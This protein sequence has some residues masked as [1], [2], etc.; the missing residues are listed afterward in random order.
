[1][2]ALKQAMASAAVDVEA[3]LQRVM[4]SEDEPERRLFDSMRYAALG[5]GKRL[6]PFLVLQG[7]VLFSV[8]RK[9]A[10]RAAAAIELVHC[11]SLVHDDLP[12]MD[13]DDLRRGKP[14]VHKAFDEATA[15]LAG[16]ALL[17]LAFE[18]LAHPDTH[19]NPEV[20]CR[21]V[22]ELARAAGAHGMV[23]GQMIDLSASGHEM[24][25][26]EI[27]R[28]QRLKTGALIGFACEAGAILGQA[29]ESQH[30][31]LRG[32]AHDLGL[33]FQI[34]D[35]LLD[36]EGT[37][38]EV[39]KAVQKD[40][41]RGKATFVSILG[42]DRARDQARMLVEQAAAHLAIFEEKADF[43]RKVAQYV[44]ERRS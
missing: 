4:A 9:S 40:S 26:G 41:D 6:R 12:A 19:S 18:V 5:G 32:Y 44:V 25:I 30:E 2:D 23:A 37:Q 21:L 28:L 13:D 17:T 42:P 16:D 8:G 33:A 11:Y 43:L 27:T 36:V 39:G 34:A 20:R 14:T 15:I 3:M 38:E 22:A 35:D 1:L 29:G 7:A 31:A 24:D 10:L